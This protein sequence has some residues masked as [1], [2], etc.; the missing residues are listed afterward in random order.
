[1]H[2]VSIIVKTTVTQNRDEMWTSYYFDYAIVFRKYKISFQG[3]RQ[4]YINGI[5]YLEGIKITCSDINNRGRFFDDNK[6]KEIKDILVKETKRLYIDD[7][8]SIFYHSIGN[9]KND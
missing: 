1:M 4:L 2:I 8:S 7:P 6:C 5:F 3:S 9:N